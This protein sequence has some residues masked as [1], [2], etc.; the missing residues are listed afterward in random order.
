M[1]LVIDLCKIVTSKLSA[2]AAEMKGNQ[3]ENLRFGDVFTYASTKFEVGL[4]QRVGSCREGDMY[5]LDN[6]VMVHRNSRTPT[7]IFVDDS[8]VVDMVHIVKG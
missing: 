2:L 8:T 6:K 4:K 1:C 3:V 7:S 5:L